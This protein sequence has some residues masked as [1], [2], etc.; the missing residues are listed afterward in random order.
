[1]KQIE[2]TQGY[3][4]IVDDEDF[5]WL[6]KLK[7]FY[8]E[9]DSGNCYAK[10]SIYISKSKSEHPYMHRM[11]MKANKG[12]QI[13]H[14]NRNGLDNQRL[15][16]RFCNYSLNHANA[17]KRLNTSSN[18]KG[19]CWD[20]ARQRWMLQVGSK[21]YGRFDD[22]IEAA[23]AYDTKAIELYGEFARTNF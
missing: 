15:N 10:T 18:Y 3:F 4:A 7:W 21:H 22:E 14:R 19:V 6:R 17:K 2:L 16:L 12:Q 8:F 23:K 1:M 11:I 13:D 9:T 5:E 20:K